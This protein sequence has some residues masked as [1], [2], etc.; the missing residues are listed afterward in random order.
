MCLKDVDVLYVKFFDELCVYVRSIIKNYDAAQDVV[1]DF[2]CNLI[3]QKI[4]LD[5]GRNIRSYLFVS[6]RNTAY[7][8]IRDSFKGVSTT[9]KPTEEL[10]DIELSSSF[11]RDIEN[12]YLEGI[13][14]K[15]LHNAFDVLEYDEHEMLDL[16]YYEN[17]S[18]ASIARLKNTNRYQVLKKIENAKLKLKNSIEYVC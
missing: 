5:P 13:V 15:D 18:I 3:E 12:F 8:Y 2:F 1:H 10:E 17:Q 7:T 6:C 14:V 9:Y 16:Y 11:F 4:E